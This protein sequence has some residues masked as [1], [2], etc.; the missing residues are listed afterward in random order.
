MVEHKAKVEIVDGLCPMCGAELEYG[1]SDIQDEY[2]WYDVACTKCPW[3][4]RQWDHI[5]FTGYTVTDPETDTAINVE[6]SDAALEAKPTTVTDRTQDELIEKLIAALDDMTG[7]VEQEHMADH[8]DGWVEG[9]PG[10]DCLTCCE[11]K[12]ATRLANHARTRDADRKA[13]NESYLLKACKAVARELECLAMDE[14]NGKSCEEIDDYKCPVCQC[15]S[16]ITKAEGSE[17]EPDHII[18]DVSGGVAYCD[19]PRVEI[20]DHDNH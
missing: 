16:A 3:E 12:E 17:P 9:E 13:Q 15:V 1:N 18:V 6:P 5:V 2:H 7:R 4:G 11:I 10:D 19:D 20:I 8:H 14:H